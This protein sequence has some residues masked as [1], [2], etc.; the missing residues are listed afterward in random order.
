MQAHTHNTYTTNRGRQ[1]RCV[2]LCVSVFVYTRGRGEMFLAKAQ[3]GI[4]RLSLPR[5]SLTLFCL[6]LA[7]VARINHS[8]AL[9]AVAEKLPRAAA[10]LRSIHYVNKTPCR[11]GGRGHMAIQ[12]Q[13]RDGAENEKKSSYRQENH[14]FFLMSGKE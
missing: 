13:A 8:A 6:F 12:L 2:C 14:F 11:M 7:A 9:L 4:R 5:T 1:S 10:Q 3:S